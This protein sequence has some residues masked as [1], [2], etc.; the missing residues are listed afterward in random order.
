MIQF[1]KQVLRSKLGFD[2][3]LAPDMSFAVIGDVHGRDDLLQQVLDRLMGND[4]NLPI[5]FVGDLVDRG[6]DSADDLNRVMSMTQAGSGTAICLKGNHE[7][8][9]L[10]FIDYPAKSGALWLRNGGDKTLESYGITAP[11][12]DHG[13]DT[14][15]TDARDALSERMGDPLID[16]LRIR[17]LV[18]QSGNVAVTHA[19]GDPAQPL[20]PRRGHGLL[21]G[22]RDFFRKP[23]QDGVWMVHGHYASE[24]AAARDGR[25]SVDT[26]A[27]AT[28]RLSAAVIAPGNVEFFNT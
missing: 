4:A 21:W 23:R 2:A 26:G 15:L 9:M 27:Y 19:G 8:M 5:A 24:Q 13:M 7:A 12:D 3:P 17:P 11:N 16:W 20:E 1:L 22:H 18:Y 28:G 10:D 25:I 6:P 14:A